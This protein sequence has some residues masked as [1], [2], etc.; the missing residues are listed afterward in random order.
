MITRH[1]PV[2]RRVDV[3]QVADLL[4]TPRR[5]VL[6]YVIGHEVHATP[7][8]ICRRGPSFLLGVRVDERPPSG[9]SKG[10]LLVDEGRYTLELRGVRIRGL[11]QPVDAGPDDTLRWFALDEEAA[12]A[13]DYGTL[14]RHAR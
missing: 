13:W 5:A 12:V 8:R 6:A 1:I 4:D 14:R 3:E 7:V 2:T 9:A 10:S 11:L